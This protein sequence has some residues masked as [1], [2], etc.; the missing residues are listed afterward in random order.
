MRRLFGYGALVAA[1]VVGGLVMTTTRS[2]ESREAGLQEQVRALQA[3]LQRVED[4]EA[5]EKLTRAYGFYVDKGQWSQI[6]DLFADDGRVEIAGRGVYIGKKSVDR[7]FRESLGG[8]KNGLAPGFLFNHLV[9]QGIVDVAPDGKTAEGRWQVFAQ[10]GMYE[11]GATWAGGIFQ[12]SYVKDGGVWKIKSMHYYATYYTPYADGWGKKAT[13]N[14]G[15]SK[16]FPPDAPQ[17]VQ[18][19]VFPGFYVPPYH[20]P[21]PVTGKPWTPDPAAK[22]ATEAQPAP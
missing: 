10:V 20:Y 6:V 9:L 22:P 13:P 11:R 5:I 21:N 12:N 8:G 15:P 14:N 18:Y 7:M 2:A 3:R 19:D 16:E 17:S 1:L 4:K